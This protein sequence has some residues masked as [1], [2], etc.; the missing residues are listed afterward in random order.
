MTTFGEVVWHGWKVLL[1]PHV[2][3]EV[4]T[5]CY[6]KEEVAMKQPPTLNKS[7]VSKNFKKR[8]EFFK[9]WIVCSKSENDVAIVRY[10]DGVFKGRKIECPVQ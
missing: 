6:V 10:G 7:C 8:V 4:H 9:T 1:R 5:N 3:Y 2:Y